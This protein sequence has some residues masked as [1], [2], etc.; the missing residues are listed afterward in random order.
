MS[1]LYDYTYTLVGA[2]LFCGIISVLG[3]SDSKGKIFRLIAGAVLLLC[4]ASPLKNL[5]GKLK[6]MD[7]NFDWS[8]K[9]DASFAEDYTEKIMENEIKSSINAC[10][11]EITGLGAQDIEIALTFEKDKYIIENICISLPGSAYGKTAA[12]KSVVNHRFGI[13]PEVITVG[14]DEYN[15]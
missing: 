7:L 10:V 15:G 8:E 11:K 9:Y 4:L 14:N 12:L 5:G 13:M 3:P 2:A 6:G 1:V